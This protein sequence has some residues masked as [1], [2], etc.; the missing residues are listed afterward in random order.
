MDLGELEAGQG[1]AAALDRAWSIATPTS[2]DKI[3]QKG[4]W[5][6]EATAAHGGTQL[7]LKPTRF[8][9]VYFSRSSRKLWWESF[10][11]TC[12]LYGDRIVKSCQNGY[13]KKQRGQSQ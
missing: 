2:Q 6:G 8:R 9:R 4:N 12:I 11:V 10:R 5:L 3:W 7:Y 13:K 1:L